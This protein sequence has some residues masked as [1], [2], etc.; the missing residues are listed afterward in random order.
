MHP[1][2]LPHLMGGCVKHRVKRSLLVNAAT[3]T[4]ASRTPAGAGNSKIFT[5]SVWIMRSRFGVRQ[6]VITA[7][8]SNLSFIGFN[9]SDQLVI[10]LANVDS[11]SNRVFRDPAGFYHIVV[12]VDL[13][14]ANA[15]DRLTVWVNGELI[16]WASY[17][18]PAQNTDDSWN[19]AVMHR[20][21]ID[22]GGSG[23][24]FGGY[25][26]EFHNVDGQALTPSIFGQIDVRS[27]SWMPMKYTG[28]HG[29]NGFYLPMI[30]DA[31]DAPATANEGLKDRSGNG[32]NF[33]ASGLAASDF[34]KSS[35]TNYR[36]GSDYRGNFCV[37]S[38]VNYAGWSSSP[39][40]NGGLRVGNGPGPAYSRI[41]GTH[42]FSAGK[43]YWEVRIT[44]SLG[45]GLGPRSG[46][47]IGNN[48]DGSPSAS[49][50]LGSGAGSW[51][52]D[53]GAAVKRNNGSSTAHGSA[54]STNDY[55]MVAVDLDSGKVWFGKNG[56]WFGGGDPAA[57]SGEAF[58]NLAGNTVAAVV[59]HDSDDVSEFNF[60]QK[61]YAYTIPNGFKPLVTSAMSRPAIIKPGAA[62]VQAVEAGVSIGAAIAAK[63]ANWGTAYID[64]IKRYDGSE[65][66]RWR[67][68]DDPGN[69]LD[70]STAVNGKQAFPVL[71]GNYWGC[72]I[73]VGAAYGV[74]TGEIAHVNGAATTVTD[75]LGTSRKVVILRRVD[76]GGQ[77]PVHHPDAASGELLYMNSS[78][79]DAPASDI[80]NVATNSFQIGGGMP[81]GTYRYIVLAEKTGL[82]SLFKY[83]AAASADG[84][85]L[86]AGVTPGLFV[87]KNR[88]GTADW[89]LLNAAMDPK[90]PVMRTLYPDLAA[91]EG[92]TQLPC[93]FT[94]NGIKIRD[95][96]VEF[97]ASA[98]YIAI[99]I[100]A[101]AFAT[102]ECAAQATAR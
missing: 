60:G 93:D 80:T 71:A 95:T 61:S 98:E 21:G 22:G 15:A 29:T 34:V 59:E 57:G 65:G 58:S 85:V 17:S 26:A 99:V 94:A 87:V 97:G 77:W 12:R 38:A 10:R 33:T 73:R 90:N 96:D 5:R 42:W 7:H 92:A 14:Q 44:G 9:A 48:T 62:F 69:Y 6:D 36:R 64:I 52:F 40:T 101:N 4:Y 8:P 70:S 51:V 16:T 89:A 13:T 55:L 102:G 49:Q 84:P 37:M 82:I 86:P 32:N 78:A 45:T 2:I 43:F 79:A 46:V 47:S 56:A 75:N 24:P 3:P 72:S 20:I 41:F 54:L 30:G 76:A 88:T 1:Y 100:A 25:I 67:F 35:P 23:N 63:R 91:A 19:S 31:G 11:I 39:V 83:A 53:C 18:V 68:G 74:A 66:W 50:T 81:T 28:V 27:G